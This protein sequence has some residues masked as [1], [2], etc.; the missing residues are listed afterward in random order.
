M[1]SDY[2]PWPS[3]QED[4]IKISVYTGCSPVDSH[5]HDFVEIVF[6][7][8]GSC[9]HS[10]R[11]TDTNLIPGDVFIVEPHEEHA[12]RISSQTIIY[13]CLFYPE[14]LGDD[15]K[16]LKN[17]SGIYDFMVV[18]PFYRHESHQQDI[19]HLPPD[20]LSDIKHILNRMISEQELRQRG[21]TLVQ[22]ANLL[23][24]LAIIGRAW[25]SQF[26][27]KSESYVVKRQMLAE[28]I[29][30]I[31]Q[32]LSSSLKIDEI[33]AMVYLSPDYFRRLFRETTGL[34]PIEYIN[35]LRISKAAKLLSAQKLTVSEAAE[36]VGIYDVNYFSR[37]FRSIMGYSPSKAKKT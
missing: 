7:M 22:K 25:E 28:A 21:S 37:L 2:L 27:S 18:E 9:V 1:S 31:E 12:Y 32:N 5:R 34:S 17:L 30:Y 6:I 20:E 16:S 8:Q 10:H 19:L 35:K 29:K 3:E 26:Q 4:L 36:L 11:D 13:N 33:A 24:L 23:M 14:A 15:W